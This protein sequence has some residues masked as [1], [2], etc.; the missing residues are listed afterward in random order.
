MEV[1]VNKTGGIAAPA[2][3]EQWG[4]IDTTAAGDSGSRLEQLIG[5]VGFFELKSDYP[6]NGPD[7]F[8]YAIQVSDGDR[9]HSVSYSDDSD[10]V[11]PELRQI[12]GLMQSLGA[13]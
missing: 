11:P 6:P 5:S 9:K 7:Q 8:A 12:T 13:A 3:D 1:T 2:T 4:P 10:D